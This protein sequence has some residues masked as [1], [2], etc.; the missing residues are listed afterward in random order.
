MQHFNYQIMFEVKFNTKLGQKPPQRR[1]G[2]H[3]SQSKFNNFFIGILV[4]NTQS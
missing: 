1:H 2:I 4:K 3:Q